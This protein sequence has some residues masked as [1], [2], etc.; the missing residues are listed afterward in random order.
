MEQEADCPGPAELNERPSSQ[1]LGSSS[2]SLENKNGNVAWCFLLI[3]CIQGKN[4]HRFLKRLFSLRTTQKPGGCLER[5]IPHLDRHFRMSEHMVVLIGMIHRTTLG[6][7]CQDGISVRNI[8][9]RNSA[10]LTR[11]RA[12]G[13]QKD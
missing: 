4:L 7:D 11:F 10:R 3:R 12:R 1:D 2:G 9:Q 13:G 6:S 8:H 5:L